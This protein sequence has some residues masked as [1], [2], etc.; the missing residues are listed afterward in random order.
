M[1]GA[2]S[3]S[4]GGDSPHKQPSSIAPKEPY[5]RSSGNPTVGRTTDLP[6]VVEA[7][8]RRVP[9]GLY[10]ELQRGGDEYSPKV[11]TFVELHS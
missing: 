8:Y 1:E 7:I 3:L 5:G 11:S 10:G 2:S 9:M 6:W 4:E